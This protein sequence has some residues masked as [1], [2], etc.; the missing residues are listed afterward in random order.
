LAE[1]ADAL[2]EGLEAEKAGRSYEVLSA[3]RDELLAAY[4]AARRRRGA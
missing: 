3:E 1:R 2:V 4:L